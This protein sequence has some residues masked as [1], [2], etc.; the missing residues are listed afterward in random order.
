M[1]V[2]YVKIYF[3]FGCGLDLF[4]VSLTSSIRELKAL[5]VL[6]PSFFATCKGEQ[7]AKMDQDALVL[8][9]DL[10]TTSV[11]VAVVQPHTRQCV[12]RAMAD[13]N[14]VMQ[15]PKI[16]H[17]KEQD[18]T[19]IMASLDSLVAAVPAQHKEKV[20]LVSVCGQMHGAV[21]WGNGSP[22]AT[23]TTSRQ[24]NGAAA[25][26]GGAAAAVA[27]TEA[28][29]TTAEGR[30]SPE[31]EQAVEGSPANGKEASSDSSVED[32]PSPMPKSPNSPVLDSP[33]HVPIALST[34]VS[35]LPESG[36]IPGNSATAKSNTSEA[37]PTAPTAST[38]LSSSGDTSTPAAATSS[39]L[40]AS[41]LF[42][43]MPRVI[44]T[45]V[46]WEDG[47]CDT[48]FLQSLPTPTTGRLSTGFGC[49]TL[50]WM[51]RHTGGKGLRHMA[52]AGTIMDLLVASM[53]G[54]CDDPIMSDQCAASWGYF[55][56]ERNAWEMEM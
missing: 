9:I 39:M 13:T 12:H 55:D 36:V 46:T 25:S 48:A 31:I 45:L 27:T 49:A 56:W 4:R 24:S 47:R 18:V 34:P 51:E 17:S 30:N 20:R 10:G 52:A 3:K 28:D 23:A 38:A 32:T 29:G 8:G 22:D 53:T 35:F 37:E 50:A 33:G 40:A 7:Q 11:K 19:M 41:P 5:T 16:Q 43:N 21:V 6:G 44:S 42:N 2:C 15:N 54:Q 14:A 26:P 1:Q